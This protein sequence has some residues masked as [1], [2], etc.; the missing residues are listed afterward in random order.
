MDRDDRMAHTHDIETICKNIAYRND[1]RT[2]EIETENVFEQETSNENIE[3]IVT[4]LD[5]T[6]LDNNQMT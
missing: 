6:Q 4:H 5:K 1:I 2:S 3:N